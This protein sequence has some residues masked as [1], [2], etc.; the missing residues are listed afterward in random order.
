M[1]DYLIGVDAGNTMVKAVLFDMTGQTIAT[2]ARNSATLQ[3]EPHFVE[4]CPDEHWQAAA[5]AI[6]D[7]VAK[8]GI[9]A[10]KIRAV[11]VAGHGNG[12]YLL[13]AQGRGLLGIQ[14]MDSRAEALAEELAVRHGDG[15]QEAA[16]SRPWAAMTP[17]LLAWIAR[18][19]PDLIEQAGH[20]LLCKDV[21]V[22][23]LTGRAGSDVSD[24]SG[25]GLLALPTLRYDDALLEMYGIA[26]LRHLLPEPALSD[27][28]VGHVTAEAAAHSGLAEGTPVVAGLFDV[29]AS[30]LGAGT[31]AA[32][33]ASIV[34]GSWSINQIFTSDLPEHSRALL[35]SVLGRDVWVSCE[36]SP[37]SAANL[38][39]FVQQFLS[40]EAQATGENAFALCNRLASESQSEDL[41]VFHPYLYAGPTP[42]ARGGFN[43][44]G[45]WHSRADMVRALY[46]GVAFNHRAHM[47]VLDPG[48][49][50]SVATLSGGAAK[51][52]LW[53]QIFA[54]TL[55]MRLRISDCEE[56]GA[57]GAA[58]AAAV[59]VGIFDNYEAAATQMASTRI[60]ITPNTQD[61][62][63]IDSRY[64]RWSAYRDA[65]AG[66]WALPRVADP[67]PWEPNEP[68]N[69]ERNRHG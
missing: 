63:A 46:E 47:E 4:R 65:L 32:G 21:I 60:E 16:R 5:G 24:L 7:C 12:L 43:E 41:P 56:T 27:D 42:G 58:M 53:A 50:F 14:S 51:S 55:G 44:I 6:R 57:R 30:A 33:E 31:A 26:G 54:D 15:I 40:A 3:P 29:L 38:E 18:E 8:A 68:N 36:A 45:N 17:V 52:S 11:G 10:T 37:T 34:A 64:A 66:V 62:A 59:G 49:S 22:H 67:A 61:R 69:M 28:V 13:D 23:G 19:R 9:D 20:A 25:C 2:V 35:T 1:T 39:W 48:R